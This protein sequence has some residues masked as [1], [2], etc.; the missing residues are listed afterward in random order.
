MNNIIFFLFYYPQLDYV[1]RKQ[2]NVL[3]ILISTDS[4]VSD[5][6]NDIIRDIN[7]TLQPFGQFNRRIIAPIRQRLEHSGLYYHRGNVPVRLLRYCAHVIRYVH[8][9]YYYCLTEA[10]FNLSSG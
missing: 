5:S 3:L 4:C 10:I 8:N 7:A 1:N 6:I 9:N 2:L